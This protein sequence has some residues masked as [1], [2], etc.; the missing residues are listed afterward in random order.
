MN[1]NAKI[2]SLILRAQNASDGGKNINVLSSVRRGYRDNAAGYGQKDVLIMNALTTICS[3]KS[4][5]KFSVQKDSERVAY[6]LVYFETR[7]DGRKYQVSFHSYDERLRRFTK[8]SHR[9]KWD[10]G[11]SR[12]SAANIY[13][14]YV[15]NGT[16]LMEEEEEDICYD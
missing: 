3:T 15:P 16:Y 11:N 6:F 4:S 9:M 7:I 8:N 10:R 12:E 1:V 13:R 2:A 14:H 5:F